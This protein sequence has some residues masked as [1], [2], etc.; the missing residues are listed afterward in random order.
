MEDELQQ[1]NMKFTTTLNNFLTLQ[2]HTGNHLATMR[3]TNST[4]MYIGT[5]KFDSL[6]QTKMIVRNQNIYSKF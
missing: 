2:R 3:I 1:I 4:H 6:Q 5:S